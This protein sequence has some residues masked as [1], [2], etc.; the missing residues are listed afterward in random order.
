MEEY[1]TKIIGGMCEYICTRIY[2]MYL[3]YANNVS[4]TAA[5]IKIWKP[6]NQVSGMEEIYRGN[7]RSYNSTRCS[8]Q[9]LVP[10]NL[11]IKVGEQGPVF[12]VVV[13]DGRL[14]PGVVSVA[15]IIQIPCVDLPLFTLQPLKLALPLPAA[16]QSLK[17]SVHRT[18][19]VR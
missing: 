16:E 5:N 1:N 11:R 17:T 9:T 13:H 8:M 4:W 3:A 10:P 15:W 2:G 19:G 14:E 12:V 6:M 7:V 18:I